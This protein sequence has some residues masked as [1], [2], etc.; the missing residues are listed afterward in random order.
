MT[1]DKQDLYRH[2]GCF[3][4]TTKVAIKRNVTNVIRVS[5]RSA[6]QLKLRGKSIRT[7]T[8]GSRLNG[9]ATLE[10]LTTDVTVLKVLSSEWKIYFHDLTH[11][12]IRS[13]QFNMQDQVSVS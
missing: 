7:N 5:V 10:C 13:F 2:F 1:T 11:V 6:S 12:D 3:N 4:R 9:K 8:Q